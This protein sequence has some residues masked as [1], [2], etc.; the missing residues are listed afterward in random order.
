ME[1]HPIKTPL[2]NTEIIF[3]LPIFNR[4]EDVALTLAKVAPAAKRLTI[5]FWKT[6]GEEAMVDLHPNLEIRVLAPSRPFLRLYQ[7]YRLVQD[8]ISSVSGPV[9]LHD[10]F[11]F[12]LPMFCLRHGKNPVITVS[13]LY[14]PCAYAIKEVY[15]HLTLA[16]R[17]RL[18]QT[19]LFLINALVQ[20]G[21]IVASDHLV[22][23]APGLIPWYAPGRLAGFR[24]KFSV[25]PNS[26]DTGRF[27]PTSVDRSVLGLPEDK[28][29]LLFVGEL[30]T[31]KGFFIAAKVVRQLHARGLPVILAAI[32]PDSE[33]ERARL[34]RVL[35]AADLSR[36]IRIVPTMDRET[37][38]SYYHTAN[39]LIYPTKYDGSPRVVIEAMA[40]GLPVVASDHPGIAVFDQAQRLMTR[41]LNDDVPGF[42]ATIT[43]LLTDQTTRR[44]QGQAAREHIGLRFSLQAVAQDY[45]NFYERILRAQHGANL[46]PGPPPPQEL[47]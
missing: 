28:F 11:G 38:V 39:L 32:G 47:E 41:H 26:V 1:K 6:G 22:A 7:L 24:K 3:F 2:R 36:L 37:F 23:Q 12:L 16:A 40:A 9:I 4:Y 29:V 45:V 25:I 46:P 43:G 33:L 42:V 13:S 18:A 27:A 20:T 31:P 14:S 34:H 8:L 5:I 19:R 10:T 21:L 35:A 44:R 17:L 15:G 30:G